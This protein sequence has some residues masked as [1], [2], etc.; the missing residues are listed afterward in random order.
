M[1]LHKIFNE[2]ISAA[3][4]QRK[5]TNSAHAALRCMERQISAALLSSFNI[6]YSAS[7]AL[8]YKY[9]R[10]PHLHKVIMLCC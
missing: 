5:Y 4:L 2:L 1:E 8:R 9:W 7:A 3:P 6:L 10:L